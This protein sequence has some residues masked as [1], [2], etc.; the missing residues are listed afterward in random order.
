MLTFPKWVGLQHRGHAILKGREVV[1]EC[2][3]TTIQI[4]LG[5]HPG[6]EQ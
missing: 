3:F 6:P 1:A 5:H 4:G 2:N